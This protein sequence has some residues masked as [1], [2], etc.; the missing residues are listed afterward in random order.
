MREAAK[1][2]F[3]KRGYE[4]AS[5]AAICRI[6]GTSQSQIIKYFTNK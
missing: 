1:A 4:A 3:A 2:L 6:A 5:T